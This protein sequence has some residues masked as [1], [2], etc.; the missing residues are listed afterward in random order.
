MFNFSLY[1][2]FIYQLIANDYISALIEKKNITDP[3]K[4]KIEISKIIKKIIEKYVAGSGLMPYLKQLKM[5]QQ[6]IL[7]EEQRL[8]QMLQEKPGSAEKTS[9][10]FSFFKK[11]QRDSMAN[12]FLWELDECFIK[13]TEQIYST[14]N[15][16]ILLFFSQGSFCSEIHSALAQI[17]MHMQKKLIANSPVSCNFDEYL[18]VKGRNFDPGRSDLF[19]YLD[20]L[21][22]FL[23]TLLL[24]IKGDTHLKTTATELIDEI[25]KI[26]RKLRNDEQEILEA[27]TEKMRAMQY[28]ILKHVHHF[29]L[30]RI[31]VES[32]KMVSDNIEKIEH[33]TVAKDWRFLNSKGCFDNYTQLLKTLNEKIDYISRILEKRTIYDTVISE[34][35]ALRSKNSTE[36]K[37]DF[38]YRIISQNELSK[39]KE[40]KCFTQDKRYST[41]E[42][43]KW[44]FFNNGKPGVENSYLCKIV[45][46]EGTLDLIQRLTKDAEISRIALLTKENEPDCI[47]VHEEILAYFN[48]LILRVEA[49]DKNGKVFVMHFDNNMPIVENLM[50]RSRAADELTYFKMQ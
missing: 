16:R 30:E 24:P 50:P 1:E 28:Y 39:I 44:Y 10:D 15:E 18:F 27:E 17:Y 5:E 34:I 21:E 20:S 40:D 22:K 12:S 35:D 32:R 36:R 45:C 7:K 4:A 31:K 9:N 47:G 8:L 46:R 11:L 38:I 33:G 19:N 41:A 6:F 14:P 43:A 26:R 48:L 25:D 2:F 3:V 37:N 23:I 49:T 42:N 29:D 13:L